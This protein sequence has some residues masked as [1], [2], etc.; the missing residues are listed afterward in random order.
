MLVSRELAEG[1]YRMISQDALRSALDQR[2][3]RGRAPSAGHE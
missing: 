2:R 1:S 3:I